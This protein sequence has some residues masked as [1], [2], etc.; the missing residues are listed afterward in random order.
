MKRKEDIIKFV[1]I[2]IPIILLS[3][4]SYSLIYFIFGKSRYI[5]QSVLFVFYCLYL[6]Y[7]YKKIN[8]CRQLCWLILYLTVM[9]IVSIMGAVPIPGKLPINMFWNVLS[10]VLNCAVTVVCSPIIYL[11]ARFTA[12]TYLI[13]GSILYAF[14]WLYCMKYMFLKEE[15]KKYNGLFLV[16]FITL[17]E[18]ETACLTSTYFVNYSHTYFVI[19]TWLLWIYCIY[20]FRRD[21]K[22][23]NAISKIWMFIFLAQAVCSAIMFI[24]QRL[25]W[26]IQNIVYQVGINHFFYYIYLPFLYRGWP[27]TQHI[28]NISQIV[29]LFLVFTLFM[30][31]KIFKQKKRE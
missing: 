6:T 17:I 27:V 15:R 9:L 5:I 11:C 3:V 8:D 14:I 25:P 4:S 12:Y 24:S 10:V 16:I 26:D 30:I 2:F 29:S 23:L 28:I 1:V 13:I 19:F 22:L 20:Y 31:S 7:L 18:M 21:D